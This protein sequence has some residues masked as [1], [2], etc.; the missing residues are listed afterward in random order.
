MLGF[1][2][3]SAL[4]MCVSVILAPCVL[5]SHLPLLLKITFLPTL[6]SPLMYP[7]A[8]RRKFSR[9]IHSACVWQKSCVLCILFIVLI[10]PLSYNISLLLTYVVLNLYTLKNPVSARRSCRL[11]TRWR[12]GHFHHW[13]L[14]KPTGTT[15]LTR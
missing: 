11:K 10:L 12:D 1:F 13:K 9:I 3:S 2:V 6:R 8:A 5:R 4:C 7:A 14:T 15:N